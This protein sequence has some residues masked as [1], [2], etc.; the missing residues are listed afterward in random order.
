V[1]GSDPYGRHVIVVIRVGPGTPA[2]D[3]V[4][5]GSAKAGHDEEQAQRLA[6]TEDEATVREAQVPEDLAKRVMQQ[7]RAVRS[8]PRSWAT[9][10]DGGPSAIL[11]PR[12]A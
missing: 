5:R 12:Q 2:K 4:T 6:A 9:M 7:H 8:L 10:P 1:P 11:D 3:G